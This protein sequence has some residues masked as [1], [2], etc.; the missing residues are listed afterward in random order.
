MSNLETKGMISELVCIEIGA[1][2]HWLSHTR[3]SLQQQVPSLSKSA[4]TRLLDSAANCLSENILC[5]SQPAMKLNSII[6][7]M[8]THIIAF[9]WSLFYIM[10]LFTSYCAV[11]ALAK[12]KFYSWLS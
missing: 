6:L 7:L 9:L 2:G 1:L 12:P 3:S 8:F 4:T 10:F 11:S 5:S